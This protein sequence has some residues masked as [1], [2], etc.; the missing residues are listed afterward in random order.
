[1]TVMLRR[2]ILI[3]WFVAF[4]LILFAYESLRANYLIPATGRQLPK[5]RLLF[6]PAG[7]IMFYNIDRSYGHAEVYGMHGT[8][9]EIIDP[10]AIFETKALG[11]DNIHRNVLIGVLYKDRAPGFCR[12]LERK[13]P[14]YDAFVVVYAQYP[15]FVTAP[16][17]VQRHVAYRCQ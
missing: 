16:D 12:Y 10:H 6:P 2:S 14:G 1:M 8:D 4:W 15:D 11:Y 7:W 3:S 5:T 17:R 9:A 13:F